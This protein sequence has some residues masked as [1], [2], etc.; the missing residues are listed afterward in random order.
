MPLCLGQSQFKALVATL[1]LVTEYCNRLR[2]QW[3]FRQ[4]S[5]GSSLIKETFGGRPKY[6]EWAQD[7]GE[8]LQAEERASLMSYRGESGWSCMSKK[9]NGRVWAQIRSGPVNALLNIHPYF[10]EMSKWFNVGSTCFSDKA[11]IISPG[12][13]SVLL[14][15]TQRMPW[16]E[17][18]L[19]EMRCVLYKE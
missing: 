9:E 18:L 11:V 15:F 4:G 10:L 8:I 1:L 3:Y 13:Q 7:S 17:H 16:P 19:L 5:Q 2:G 14:Y 12:Q 6:K